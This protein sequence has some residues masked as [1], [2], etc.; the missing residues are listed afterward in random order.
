MSK[1]K[2]EYEVIAYVTL[3][4]DAEGEAV[5]EALASYKEAIYPKATLDDMLKTIA[6]FVAEHGVERMI[7]G[8]GT[9]SS[10]YKPRDPDY[11]CGVH[12]EVGDFEA[13]EA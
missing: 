7:E 1:T 11:W 3:E 12:V 9:V 2:K 8:V 13:L 4:F 6:C 5:Q 10:Y